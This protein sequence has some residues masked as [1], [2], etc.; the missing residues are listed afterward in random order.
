MRRDRIGES[1]RGWQRLTASVAANEADLPNLAEHRN[2]LASL[3]ELI[4]NLTLQ[5]SALN[6]SKQE[7]TSNLQDALAEA[8]TVADFLRTGVRLKYG[9]SSQKLVEFG[10]RPFRGRAPQP[11]P[12]HPEVEAPP[13][14]VAADST[15]QPA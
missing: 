2:R 4:E 15:D 10:I 7:T 1:T 6:A 14:E 11:E 8:H 13:A 12:D 5:Q 3:L 9:K